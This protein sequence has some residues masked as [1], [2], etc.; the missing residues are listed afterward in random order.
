MCKFKSAIAVEDG[1]SKGGFRL[2]ANQWTESHTD[3]IALFK[4]RDDA[5]LRFARVEFYPDN[6][7]DMATPAK[8]QLHIDEER[9]PDWFDQQKQ[10]ACAEQMR[11]WIK[12]MIVEGEAEILCGGAYILAEGAKVNTVKNA[13]I[14]VMMPK[15]NVGVM[16]GSSNVGVMWGSS[17][18]GVMWGSSK[19]GVMRGSSNVGEMRE[20]SNV[21]EMWGSS[22]VGEMRESSN[23]GVMWGSSK[24]TT[25]YRAHARKEATP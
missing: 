11:G 6:E 9:T 4:L 25:D 1:K 20:S 12:A 16:W 14:H 3:L 22:N 7:K 17:N 5:R 19:V 24:V 21:G 2:L 8:Y 15:S 10:D 13:I 23:V 18:V